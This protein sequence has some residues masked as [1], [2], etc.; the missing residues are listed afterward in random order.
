MM[1]VPH[2]VPGA[3]RLA[4]VVLAP[5]LALVNWQ[6][7][8]SPARVLPRAMQV[9]SVTRVT[10]LA[11]ALQVRQQAFELCLLSVQRM[12]GSLR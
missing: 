11:R 8:T 9:A 3:Q 5:S 10:E 12:R 7:R 4:L 1:Q 2:F 6:L